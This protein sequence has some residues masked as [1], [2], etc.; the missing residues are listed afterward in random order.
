MEK[1]G[2]GGVGAR[3]RELRKAQGLTQ[4]EL[5]ERLHVRQATV[6]DYENGKLQF[7]ADELPRVASVL[8]VDV[9]DLFSESKPGALLTMT[10]EELINLVTTEVQAIFKSARDTVP[11]M[12]S[13]NGRG[14][15]HMDE[16]NPSEAGDKRSQAE[17]RILVLR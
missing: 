11:A 1:L 3:V 15:T 16:P 2:K 7:D 13:D 4:T 14:A 8:G 17:S 6:S 10:R 12:T 9:A 5:A